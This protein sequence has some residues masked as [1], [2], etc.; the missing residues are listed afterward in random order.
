MEANEFL[1][2]D[3]VDVVNHR[4]EGCASSLD[5]NGAEVG[6][7][8]VWVTPGVV[9]DIKTSLKFSKKNNI[10]FILKDVKIRTVESCFRKFL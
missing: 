2:R 8:E 9:V 5:P 6:K 7:V 10:I 3:E 4:W 1:R